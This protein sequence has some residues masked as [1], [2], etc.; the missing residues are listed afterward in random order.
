MRVA[1]FQTKAK[2]FL[3]RRVRHGHTSERSSVLNVVTGE[4][5]KRFA[6]FFGSLFDDILRELRRRRVFVPIERLKVVA[7]ELFIEARRALAD[8]VLI[9]GP[10]TRRVRR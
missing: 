5:A 8:D 2:T 9:G 10:E 4:T 6:I 7:H 1:R 3:G